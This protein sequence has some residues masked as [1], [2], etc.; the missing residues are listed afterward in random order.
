MPLPRPLGPGGEEEE[1]QRGAGPP[2]VP[3]C[4]PPA[5]GPRPRLEDL[6]RTKAPCKQD[7]GATLPTPRPCP[8]S[9][10]P[11]PQGAGRGLAGPEGAEL[12]AA[13]QR[14]QGLAVLHVARVPRRQHVALGLLVEQ[15][16]DLL[17]VDLCGREGLLSSAGGGTGV[18]GSRDMGRLS[19][20][21]QA[22]LGSAA[23][24]GAPAA[25]GKTRSFGTA[26]KAR[27]G[28]RPGSLLSPAR[29]APDGP[30]PSPRA[31]P[32]AAVQTAGRAARLDTLTDL[33]AHPPPGSWGPRAPRPGEADGVWGGRWPC[34]SARAALAATRGLAGPAAGAPDP[35]GP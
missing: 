34:P 32:T 17:V 12:H 18:Q 25:W 10:Q 14:A 11:S 16:Q 27:L 28:K 35:G 24:P 31:Q 20:G 30:V 19:T 4:E 8:G 23:S 22:R 21:H 2:E 33:P 9:R 5:L 3:Q 7:S 13:H 15:P 26:G 1:A 29:P 6:E